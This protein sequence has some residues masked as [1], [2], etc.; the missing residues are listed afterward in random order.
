MN[1]IEQ[2]KETVGVVLGRFQL[3]KLHAGHRALIRKVQELHKTVVIV[4]AVAPTLFNRKNP[5]PGAL[6]KALLEAEFKGQKVIVRLLDNNISDAVWSKNFDQL[7]AEAVPDAE[8]VI[9]GARDNSLKHYS[10]VNQTKA[11][12]LNLRTS[13]TKVRD[14]IAKNYPKGKRALR[15]FA[16][17][18][19]H[20]TA[21][22]FPT[23]YTAVDLAVI[24]MDEQMRHEVLVCYK[25]QYDK[26][27]LCGGFVDPT[28]KTLLDAVIRE[29]QEELGVNLAVDEYKLIGDFLI[30]DWRYRGTEH[31]VRSMLYVA[32]CRWGRAIP[33]DD[34]DEVKWVDLDELPKVVADEHK[35]LAEAVVAHIDK[36][37][38]ARAQSLERKTDM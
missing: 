11:L 18:V 12:D 9:Y 36:K 4:I 7:L 34:I 27:F 14:R 3:P 5:L 21:N 10:G 38:A 30:D 31:C 37:Y 29:K 15:G 23:S 6:R 26:W 28:D 22:L 20:A 25:K 8:F 2:K 19:I 32:V 17:G 16:E 35:P 1:T 13:A 24:H 33:G